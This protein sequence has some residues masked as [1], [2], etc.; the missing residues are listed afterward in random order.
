MEDTLE[1]RTKAFPFLV[2]THVGTLLQRY[3]CSEGLVPVVL[4][5]IEGKRTTQ[6]ANQVPQVFRKVF[7]AHLVKVIVPLLVRH[8]H[9]TKHLF[10]CQRNC[11]LR[12]FWLTTIFSVNVGEIPLTCLEKSLLKRLIIENERDISPGNRWCGHTSSSPFV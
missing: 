3:F 11:V 6:V 10:T 1:R 12:L 5:F 2:P 4:C 7:R 8:H 9:E